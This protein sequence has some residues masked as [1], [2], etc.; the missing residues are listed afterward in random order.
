MIRIFS[1]FGH[2]DIIF[3]TLLSHDSVARHVFG[4]PAPRLGDSWLVK[5]RYDFRA[6]V[7]ALF[8]QKGIN[9]SIYVNQPF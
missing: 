1:G 3:T 9:I 4:R 8:P 6:L 5:A 7:M 2:R